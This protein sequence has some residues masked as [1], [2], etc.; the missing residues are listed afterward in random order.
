MCLNGGDNCLQAGDGGVEITCLYKVI[1]AAPVTDIVR[2][3]GSV[4]GLDLV[5]E[6]ELHV[7]AGVVS[8]DRLQQ[9]C[10]Y[11]PLPNY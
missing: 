5:G 3:I 8:S 6:V 7:P 11:H 9:I 2:W 1:L 10:R 4:I